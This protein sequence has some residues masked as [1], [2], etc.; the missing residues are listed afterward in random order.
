MTYKPWKFDVEVSEKYILYKH[1]H[2]SC[3]SMIFLFSQIE[4]PLVDQ[5]TSNDPSAFPPE[6]LLQA[7]SEMTLQLTLTKTSI[8]L[9][10]RLAKVSSSCVISLK[11]Y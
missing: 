4:R 9:I 8:A 6:L 2:R 11:I 1:Y 10:T 7:S 5:S 3:F